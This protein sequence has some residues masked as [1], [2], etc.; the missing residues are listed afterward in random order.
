MKK[1]LSF[2]LVVVLIVSSSFN[3]YAN[4]YEVGDGI[5]DCIDEAENDYLITGD[6]ESAIDV[7]NDCVDSKIKK[8][9]RVSTEN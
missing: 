8:L 9:R 5:Q 3:L 7:Y 2:S 6:M 4:N 1:Y